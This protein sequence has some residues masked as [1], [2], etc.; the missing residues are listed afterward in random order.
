MDGVVEELAR[1]RKESLQEALRASRRAVLVVNT[2]SRRGR[3]LYSL[4]KELLKER[5]FTLDAAY[6]VR[7]PAR[8]RETVQGAI[9]AGHKLVIVGGG[10]GTISSV[11]DDFA[12]RNVVLGLL[13]LGTANSF[14]RTLGVPLTVEGAVDVIA[15]CRVVDV[16][17]GT[18]D[19][20][21][22]ANA[23]AIG[24]PASI[25]RHMPRLVKRWFGRLGYLMVAAVRLARH[26]SFHCTIRLPDRTVEVEALEVRI[27]NGQHQGGVMVAAEASVES[28]DLAVQVIRG[29]SPWSI[30]RFWLRAL[31]GLPPLDEDVLLVRGDALRIDTHPQQYVS[32]DG[33]PVAQT[34]IVAAVSRQSL[35]VLAPMDRRDLR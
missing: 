31:V 18:I 26:R 15:A 33:E 8:L 27:A 6:P 3:K 22:F 23:A 1:E 10:D 13:P 34:P 35:H 7:D 20:N 4:A 32:I 30:A 29:S 9:A 16:D 28:E 14:T 11:V 25:A 2:R 5:G 19:G 17:L 24:L 21:Y 12:H